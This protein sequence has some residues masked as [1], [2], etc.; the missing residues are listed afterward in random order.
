M[1]PF[2][3]LGQLKM[4]NKQNGRTQFPKDLEAQVEKARNEL[5]SRS[6]KM[7]R[8]LQVC[9]SQKS[10][11]AWTETYCGFLCHF[12]IW[13]Y[14]L[15]TLLNWNTHSDAV[16]LAERRIKI[17][18]K[19]F[20]RNFNHKYVRQKN[21][22]PVFDSILQI[23][24]RMFVCFKSLKRLKKCYFRWAIKGHHVPLVLFLI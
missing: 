21:T 23:L 6:Q 3:E 14:P 2:T 13:M 11:L 1:Y 10:P 7:R 20:Y 22:G 16:I 12:S 18:W 24:F 4:Q 5:V 17:Y 8:A 15:N 9:L 19:I